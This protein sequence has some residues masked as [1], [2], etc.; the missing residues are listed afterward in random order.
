MFSADVFLSMFNQAAHA[1]ITIL[2]QG[3]S[4]PVHRFLICPQSIY[5]EEACEQALN[6]GERTL[7]YE[8]GSGA[9]YWRVFE[10]LYTGSYCDFLDNAELKGK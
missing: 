9:A 4:I 2:I 3:V 7:N 6:R 5:L 1:D 8:Q 10:Y